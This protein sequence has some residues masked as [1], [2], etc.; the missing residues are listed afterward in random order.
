VILLYTGRWHV[1]VVPLDGYEK[2]EFAVQHFNITTQLL[3]DRPLIFDPANSDC[4]NEEIL[5][6]TTSIHYY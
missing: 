4:E 6:N 2:G 1:S 5:R 3:S